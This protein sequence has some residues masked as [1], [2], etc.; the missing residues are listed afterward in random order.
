VAGRTLGNLK[1]LALDGNAL[2][3]EEG[4]KVRERERERERERGAA[5][6]QGLQKNI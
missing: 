4:D 3:R 6:G 2:G 1:H 5:R